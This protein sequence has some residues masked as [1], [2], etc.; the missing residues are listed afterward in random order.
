MQA[1]AEAGLTAMISRMAFVAAVLAILLAGSS[2][3][4]AQP[5]R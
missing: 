2:A 5:I 1:P 4:H 3:E